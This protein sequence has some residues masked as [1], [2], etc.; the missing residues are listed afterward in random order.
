MGV[1]MLQIRISMDMRL[2]TIG[3]GRVGDSETHND[4]RFLVTG[5]VVI[6]DFDM[7]IIWI[8]V[9]GACEA[10]FCAT[11]FLVLRGPCGLICYIY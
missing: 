2:R 9:E 4:R 7:Q 3:K 8:A 6:V 11:M 1:I 5:T 10:C